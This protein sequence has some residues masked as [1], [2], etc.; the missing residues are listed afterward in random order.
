MFARNRSVAYGL[1][2]VAVALAT[3]LR[4]VLAPLLGE[5]V[6]FILYYPTIVLCAWFGGLWPG[7]LSAALGGSIAW[8][9]FIPPAYS[10]K[11]SD[12]AAPAGLIVFLLASALISLL[13]ES[14]HRTRRKTEQSEARERE[15]HER[16]RV[17]LAR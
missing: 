6:P 3:L 14:L 2:I 7:L 8:Y 13:A 5:G 12:P 1:T 9:L 11:F 4:F 15:A 16:L 17:T 10:F